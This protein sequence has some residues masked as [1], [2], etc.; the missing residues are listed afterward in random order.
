MLLLYCRHLQG[1]GISSRRTFSI[2]FMPIIVIHPSRCMWWGWLMLPSIEDTV[3]SNAIK[4][5]YT[6]FTRYTKTRL[7]PVGQLQT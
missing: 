5:P 7:R 6:L 2:L 3:T 1:F 4:V